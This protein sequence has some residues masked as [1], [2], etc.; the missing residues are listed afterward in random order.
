MF[1]VQWHDDIL[2]MSQEHL[3]NIACLSVNMH[4][5]V[6]AFVRVYVCACVLHV[7][8]MFHMRVCVC[9]FHPSLI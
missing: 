7:L 4:I 6:C 2:Y 3:G 9:S 1:W 5:G 8:V